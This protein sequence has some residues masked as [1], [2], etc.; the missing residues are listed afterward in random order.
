MKDDK[1]SNQADIY[2]FL[3]QLD[4]RQ[5]AELYVEANLWQWPKMLDAIKPD[6]FD[7]MTNAEQRQHSEWRRMWHALNVCT[8]AYARSQAWWLVELE[9]TEQQHHEWFIGG[10]FNWVS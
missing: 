1:T 10:G 6:G 3:M 9:R 7:K 2:G 8:S 4:E 5:R